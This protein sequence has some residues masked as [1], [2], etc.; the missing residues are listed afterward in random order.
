METHRSSG[1]RE[2][3]AMKGRNGN[4]S[5]G[6]AGVERAELGGIRPLCRTF[7]LARTFALLDVRIMAAF[8]VAR[9]KRQRRSM[10]SLSAA[11]CVVLSAYADDI[12]TCRI[13]PRT[14][15]N[16]TARDGRR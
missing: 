7:T 12:G 16:P 3:C 14:R 15:S 10:H 4:G 9:V 13:G 2:T 11:R 1:D 5:S 6:V 8:L